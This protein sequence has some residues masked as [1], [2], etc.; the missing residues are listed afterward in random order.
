[1]KSFVKFLRKAT[2][3]SIINLTQLLKNNRTNFNPHA[4]VMSCIQQSAGKKEY[5]D[6][7]ID[8]KEFDLRQL[9]NIINPSCLTVVQTRG[10]YHVLVKIA[11]I[12]PT[13]KSSFFQSFT[14]FEAVDQ[15]GDQLLPVPGCTQGGYVP[16]FVDLNS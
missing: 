2:F 15:S 14:A 8:D 11:D 12:A 10:G 3:D 7:D 5:L 1:M 16:K 6:F 4:E 9:E 13:Y